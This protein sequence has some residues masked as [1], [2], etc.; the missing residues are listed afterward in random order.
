MRVGESAAQV[1]DLLLMVLL[2][3]HISMDVEVEVVE[4]GGRRVVLLWPMVEMGV[5]GFK[6]VSLF[7]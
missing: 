4:G 1:R 6:V 3:Y 7:A 2:R 5:T